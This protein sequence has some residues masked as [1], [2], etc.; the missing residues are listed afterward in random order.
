M[1]TEYPSNLT[2]AE[3]AAL[4]V[5]Y[6]T[7]YGGL[8]HIARIER[9]DFVSIPA[10]S[11]SVGLAAIQFVRD[12]TEGKGVRVSFDPI[13]GPFVEQLAAASANH[14]WIWSA[15]GPTCALPV[16]PLIGK[17]LSSRGYTVSE[18]TRD[19]AIAEIAKEYIYNR[20]AHSRFRLKVDKIFTLN[21]TAD[22]YRYVS[23]NQQIG[24]VVVTSTE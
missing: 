6:L 22:A 14:R 2:S 4:W 5:P 16:M 3:A 15:V 10:G 8:V 23:S 11:S 17:G 20:L 19:P 21:E 24:R 13:G 9:G 12:I 18:V 1:Y 7:A